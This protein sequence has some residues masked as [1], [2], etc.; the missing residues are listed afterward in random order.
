M[1]D[2]QTNYSYGTVSSSITLLGNFS[3][4][5]N[6]LIFRELQRVSIKWSLRILNWTIHYKVSFSTEVIISHTFQCES[7]AFLLLVLENL[8]KYHK[9]DFA[10]H[11]SIHNSM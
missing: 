2:V 8:K 1:T 11:C 5:S 6:Y 10:G 3:K 7:Y 9:G 4:F